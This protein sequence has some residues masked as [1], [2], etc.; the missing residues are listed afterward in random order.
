MPL[1]EPETV[2][3][4]TDYLPPESI[5]R[6]KIRE[7]IKR[8]FR[9]Y[10]F[11]PI[12]TPIIEFEEL[13]RPDIQE[14]E[15]EAISDRFRLKDKGGRNLGLRYEFTFQLARVLKENPNLKMPLR[16][17]QI[18]QVF[19]DEPVRTG[20]TRQFTQCDVD[21][22][23]DT[24]INAEAECLYAGYAV[25]NELKIDTEIIINNRKLINALIESVEISEVKQVM[26]ELDKLE[27]IGQDEVKS[28]L[29]KYA[30]SN[31]IVTLFKL[32]EKSLDFFIENKFEGSDEIMELLKLCKMYSIKARFSPT[33]VRGLGYYT[34]NIFEAQISDKKIS[35]A[36]GGRYDKSVGKFLNREIPAVGFSFS[37]EALFGLC[38]EQISKVKLEKYPRVLILSIDRD[39]EAINLA[40]RLRKENISCVASFQK[41][42]K[43]LE[44]ANAMDIPF[45]IFIGNE[46]VSKK[47][48]KLKNMSSGEE[49]LLS[50]KQVINKLKN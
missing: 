13:M 12:E 7:I 49:A 16:R 34:G 15:D 28:N 36:G 30:S 2:K 19:R 6:E 48:L 11:R 47:K 42:G 9:L 38:P 4:F 17:Y 24:S 18:G 32:L 37:L 23:G 26:R 1:F 50:E 43:A 21:I 45:T 46:E 25:F 27:K 29:R 41:P 10:G 5:K 14:Q 8:T 44:Y 33:L 39:K 20:R 35:I 40:K 22:I 3:G 31:Q